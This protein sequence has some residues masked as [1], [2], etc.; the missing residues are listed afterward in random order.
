[1]IDGSEEEERSIGKRNVG[2]GEYRMNIGRKGKMRGD[3]IRRR[4]IE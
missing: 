3:K 2:G 1:L 4:R